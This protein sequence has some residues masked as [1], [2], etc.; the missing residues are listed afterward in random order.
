MTRKSPI[1]HRVRAHT[2]EGKPVRSFIRGQQMNPEIRKR[3]LTIKYL[4]KKERSKWANVWE[5]IYRGVSEID[6]KVDKVLVSFVENKPIAYI[7]YDLY[8]PQDTEFDLNPRIRKKYVIHLS[9]IDSHK[10]KEGEKL[11]KLMFKNHPKVHAVVMDAETSAGANFARRF[12][13]EQEEKGGA[14]GFG[15]WIIYRKAVMKEK[16]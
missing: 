12:N 4:T 13:A 10:H 6:S 7:S 16:I 15:T 9:F 3:K 8:T 11:L 14:Y 2:R 5:K 1:R